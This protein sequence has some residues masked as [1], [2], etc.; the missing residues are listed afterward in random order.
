MSQ[1]YKIFFGQITILITSEKNIPNIRSYL[2]VSINKKTDI[3]FITSIIKIKKVFTNIIIHSTNP[4]ETFN[5]FKKQ[6]NYVKAAGGVVIN[7]NQEVLFI[8]RKGKWDLPKGK[9]EP[10]ENKKEAALRE[11]IE[12]T[13]L[14]HIKLDRLLEETYHIGRVKGRLILKKTTWY[15]MSCKKC[16]QLTPQLEEGITNIK[17]INLKS[18]PGILDKTYKNLKAVL[19]ILLKNMD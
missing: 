10:S 6:F 4:K 2:I 5:L 11:V 18:N 3:E 12:E 7:K 19:I 16:N 9:L 1:S 8:F 15:L 14:K 17:W 13:G